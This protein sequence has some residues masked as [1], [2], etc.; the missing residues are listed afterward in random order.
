[1]SSVE[2]LRLKNKNIY[3]ALHADCDAWYVQLFEYLA[4]KSKSS[5][6]MFTTDLLTMKNSFPLMKIYWEYW[7]LGENSLVTDTSCLAMK[8]LYFQHIHK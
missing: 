2:F 1:M 4:S 6:V 5:W 8:C 3:S 7:F